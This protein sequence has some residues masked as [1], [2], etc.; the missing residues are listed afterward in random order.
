MASYHLS[1]FEEAPVRMAS[2]FV[3]IYRA[4][5]L[6]QLSLGNRGRKAVPTG[7]FKLTEITVNY[8]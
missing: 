3:D 2:K 7:E 5:Q 8:L 6:V 1:I 4:V